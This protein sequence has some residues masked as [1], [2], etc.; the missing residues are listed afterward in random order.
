MG[1]IRVERITEYLCDPLGIAL[2]DQD[3]Y[4]RKTAAICVA[5]LYDIQ[6]D[7]VEERGFI[8]ILRGMLSDVNPMV[9][10][11]A[12]AALTEISE[13]SGSDH[14]LIDGNTLSKLL[15]A[16]ND[17]TEW[18]R[19]FILDALAK[20]E[21]N[22][23]Q[24][25]DICDRV[26]P[27]LQHA[28]SAVVM[29][30]VRVVVK[31]M[32]KLKQELLQKYG[33]KLAPPLVT[34]VSNTQPEIQYVTLRNIDLIVQR[35]PKILHN[36]VLLL[37]FVIR[38]FFIKF[39][40]ATYVKMEKLEILIKLAN[41]NNAEQVL[42]E[43][44]E[45]ATEIDVE[46]ARKAVRAIGRVAI[47]LEAAAE[48][49]VKVLSEL[50]KTKVT[51]VVQ[52]S[53]IVIKDIFRRYPQRYEKII[54]TLCENLEVLDEPEA[55]ASMVWIIGEYAERIVDAEER[56]EYFIES[57]E[58]EDFTVQLQ[59]LT[60]TVKLFLKKPDKSKQLV[61]KVLN[62]ATE[63]SDNPD[64]R[65][66]GYVYWRLLSSDPAAAK[67]VVLASRPEISAE[68]FSL[69]K[70][71]L[72]ELLENVSTLA[73]VYQRPPGEFVRGTRKVIFKAHAENRGEHEESSEERSGGEESDNEQ[74]QNNKDQEKKEAEDDFNDT[75]NGDDEE[76]KKKKSKPKEEKKR[77]PKREPVEEKK[78]QEVDL[79]GDLF[80]PTP[81]VPT[82]SN[83][84]KPKPNVSSTPGGELDLLGE[85]NA[86]GSDAPST[87][88]KA[89]PNGKCIE[90]DMTQGIVV[91]T[92]YKRANNKPYLVVRVT[93]NGQQGING[94][95][96]KFNTN[97]LGAQPIQSLPLNG[98]VN[99][100]FSQ[101]AEVELALS[102]DAQQRTP[103]S[104]KVQAAVRV[105]LT[106][107]QKVVH[108]FET[109][110]P[111]HVFL[112]SI[113]VPKNDYLEK[114]KNI[115]QTDG[116]SIQLKSVKS[117]DADVIKTTLSK[118]NCEFIARREIQDKGVSL[119]FAAKLRNE[120]MLIEIAIATM[121]AA[122]IQVRADN[123][124][125]AFITTNAIQ[126]LIA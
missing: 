61:Q 118:N 64:L 96:I 113:S 80:G 75:D 69:P 31:H 63:K 38:V 72:N 95:D 108:K 111:P 104:A 82:K 103:F 17:C 123:K 18:G 23:T 62:L 47:K 57:F 68:T 65:D 42:M 114:W 10:A 14:F 86:F 76:E 88:D 70:D 53:V 21:A 105:S 81:T 124:Y 71:Y 33:K 67:A 126:T 74:K 110:V 94:M 6:S 46:F 66:R 4:V 101:I 107:G 35:Y 78:V 117:T 92:G 91:D 109:N 20:F 40:D 122:R 45:Y 22:A 115:P 26:V 34:L 125:L 43:L 116:Q 9:V 121:G 97:Y 56:L 25:K 32:S 58:E 100:G 30:A 1:C 12:V 112:D 102:Q 50:V 5:K 48:S 8:E 73:A 51:Y 15:T 54:V 37:L 90:A 16:L 77:S 119:Y 27:Q 11:N 39:N 2:K 3:P 44:K 13:S 93:N 36:E 24:A 106:S 84:E 89:Y 55:K 49:C 79:L 87:N 28:N 98:T 60:A 41:K 83:V 7:L 85:F 99:A 52:E 19:V 29:A 120:L 59:L